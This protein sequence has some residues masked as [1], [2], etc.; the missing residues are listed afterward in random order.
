ML[1]PLVDTQ[2]YSA[3]IGAVAMEWASL[4]SFVHGVLWRLAGLDSRKGRCI[5]QHVPFGTVWCS[6]VSLANEIPLSKKELETLATLQMKC[7]PLR[8]KRNEI[9]HALW[10]ITAAGLS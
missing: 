1:K 3:A 2:A 8:L 6:I 9:V 5:T 10:G 4:E 7:E